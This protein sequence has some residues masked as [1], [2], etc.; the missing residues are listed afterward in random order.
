M[1]KVKITTGF[2]P[3]S[4]QMFRQLP[5][6]K[7][8]SRCGKYQFFINESIENPDFWVVRNKFQRRRETCNIAPQNTVLMVSEPRS[9]V[10]FPKKYRDQFGMLCT[11][12]EGV[13]HKNVI[14][15]PAVLPWFVGVVRKNG[16]DIVTL[17]YDDLKSNAIPEKTKLLSVITSSKAFT[18][19]HQNR[20]KF[21][22][23][24]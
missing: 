22:E 7:N 20:I 9:I 6:R 2:S 3:E 15:C 8:I 19:G 17:D 5:G 12:Q 18:Q 10:N 21:V 16:V 24:L 14:Y 13:K 4:Q 1:Y 23:K 11:C